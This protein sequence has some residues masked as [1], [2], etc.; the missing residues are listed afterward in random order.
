MKGREGG[1]EGERKR[2]R[3]DKRKVREIQGSAGMRMPSNFQHAVLND[4]SNMYC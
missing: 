2:G 3:K 4:T 1:R